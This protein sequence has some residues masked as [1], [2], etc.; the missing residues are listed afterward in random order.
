MARPKIGFTPVFAERMPGE[1]RNLKARWDG[2]PARPPKKGE[3]YLSGCE[4]F[5]RAYIAPND[6]S[7][8]FFI[9][10]RLED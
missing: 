7:T 3:L 5:E 1:R 2:K 8:P 4:G 9:C 6:L 10:T